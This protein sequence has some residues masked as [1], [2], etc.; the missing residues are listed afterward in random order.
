MHMY[1]N[2]TFYKKIYWYLYWYVARTKGWHMRMMNIEL[3]MMCSEPLYSNEFDTVLLYSIPISGLL[4]ENI[5]NNGLI[6]EG[7]T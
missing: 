5:V 2:D 6:R 3:W 4:L 7:T 1:I